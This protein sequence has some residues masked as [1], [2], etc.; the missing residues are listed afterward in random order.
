[1]THIDNKIENAK[2]RH[3][4]ENRI[5][6]INYDSIYYADDTIIFSQ[7]NDAILE[8]LHLTEHFS[9]IYGLNLNQSKCLCIRMH[10]DNHIAF[11]DQV[12]VE[13]SENASYLGNTIN[14]KIDIDKEI[15]NR[16]L[17][18]CKTWYRLSLFWKYHNTDRDKRWKILVYQSVI[19]S[20][21]LYGLET[22][23][24]T[25][26]RLNRLDAFFYKGI[27]KILHIPPSFIDRTMTNIKV[28]EIANNIID[29]YSKNKHEPLVPFSTHY[30]N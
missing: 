22:I 6:Y 30:R 19:K 20:K 15:N 12:A 10:H 16:L 4:I 13:N 28:L 1:M 21:L 9:G 14:H 2:S 18:T 23:Q 24:L 11:L 5:P 17:D 8:M 25:R 7:S 27:R 3:I 29:T 26:T